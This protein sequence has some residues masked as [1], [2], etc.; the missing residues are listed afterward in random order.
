MGILESTVEWVE[1][2]AFSAF[3]GDHVKSGAL[4]R[5]LRRVRE[6]GLSNGLLIFEAVDRA[7]RQGSMTFFAMLHEFLEAGFSIY[8]LDQ[9]DTEPFDKKAPPPFF[10]TFLSMKADIAQYESQRKSDFSSKNWEKRRQLAREEKKVF[11][12]ECP[13]WLTVADG[14]Y[15]LNEVYAESIEMVF[16]L[17]AQKWGVCKIARVANEQ[18]WPVP[19]TGQKWH[20]SL[21]NRLFKNR[22]LIGEFQ[23]HVGSKSRRQPIGEPIID[24]YPIAIDPDLFHSVQRVRSASAAFP[25]RTDD[26][27]YNYLMGFGKCGCGGTWR[28]LNKHSGKQKG[29]AQYTCSNRQLGA[30][31]CPNLSGK[32]FDANFIGLACERIPELITVVDDKRSERKGSLENQLSDVERRISRLLDLFEANDDGLPEEVAERLKNAKTQ[33]VRIRES[34]RELEETSSENP[35]DFGDAVSAYLP[36]FIDYFEDPNSPA[37]EEAQQARALFRGKLLQSV[38]SVTVEISRESMTIRLLNGSQFVHMF[39]HIEFG[40]ESDF[41][42]SELEEMQDENKIARTQLLAL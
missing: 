23:P 19:A 26:K 32:V 21:L 20:L 24:Y 2:P 31:K 8:F 40:L 11:T 25:N 39:R 35:F 28:R 34:L 29:Y 36:A 30:S 16:K 1:D 5:L 18:E 38:E 4:G 13:R 6:G 22:A 9:P 7:S 15:V 17:A 33:R 37:A 14:K 41:T 3:H 12:A 27:N 10:F 42:E